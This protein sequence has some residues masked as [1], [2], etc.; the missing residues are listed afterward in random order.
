[1]VCVSKDELIETVE[2]KLAVL[3][4]EY[5]G[6]SRDRPYDGQPWTD[7]GLRGKTEVTGVTMRD[8]IDCLYS[9]MIISSRQEELQ[10]LIPSFDDPEIGE[11]TYG[12]IHS[13]NM[14]ELDPILLS[15]NFGCLV[16]KYMGI[17]PNVPEIGDPIQYLEDHNYINCER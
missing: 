11:W 12:D 3:Q 8:L 1:M 17:F 5:S 4:G 15:Q 7:Q 10:R 13:V 9:A 6:N 14:A 16:E 2:R